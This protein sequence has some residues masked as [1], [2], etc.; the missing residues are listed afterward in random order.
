M[1]MFA[2]N[3]YLKRVAYRI[4]GGGMFASNHY[5]KRVAYR[6]G[7]RGSLQVTVSSNE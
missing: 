1:G 5:L 2:S 3:H 4:G 6:L 7:D